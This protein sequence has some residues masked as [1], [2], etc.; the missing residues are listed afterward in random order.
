MSGPVLHI[1]M[2]EDHIVCDRMDLTGLTES[3]IVFLT[4]DS[5]GSHQDLS[6]IFLMDLFQHLAF[7]AAGS[8]LMHEHDFV[9][10]RCLQ[11]CCR[12]VVRNPSLVLADIQQHGKD[13]LFRRRAGIQVVGKHFVQIL[14]AL[15]NDNLFAFKVCNTERR[16][17]ID[18]GPGLI[19]F[20]DLMNAHE[21]LH[22]GKRQCEER[23][24][25]GT[26]HQ[27]IISV[28]FSAGAE[29]KQNYALIL[30]PFHGLFA[31]FGKLVSVTVFEIRLVRRQIISDGHAVG[32][33]APHIVFHEIDNGPVFASYD[34][35]LFKYSLSGNGI[36]NIEPG[37]VSGAEAQLLQL[38]FGLRIT[39]PLAVCHSVG[40]VLRQNKS[41]EIG[42]Y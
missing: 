21:A 42:V 6:V 23:R 19:V 14:A 16:S 27:R 1:L 32:I 25:G 17:H 4:A 41:I 34:F 10:I 18:D 24:I 12:C 22:V 28:V 40:Q 2:R 35:R 29:G 30:K 39:A 26:Y 37:A 31:Q 20:S 9:L 7:A 15:M 13:A 11:Q 5:V 36:C 3:Q 8:S 33:A 38:F